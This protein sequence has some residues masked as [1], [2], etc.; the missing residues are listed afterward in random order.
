MEIP[1]DEKELKLYKLRHSCTHVMAQAV[2][3]L[4]PG[5]RLAI[6]P[7][8][9]DGFYYDFEAKKPFTPEDLEKIETRMKEIIKGNFPFEQTTHSKE[10]ALEVFSKRN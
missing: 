5:T 2:L 10:E 6:G 7:P 1:K 8:V 3:E 9:E 4:F